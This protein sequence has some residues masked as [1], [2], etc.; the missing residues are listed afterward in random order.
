MRV[1]PERTSGLR[2]RPARPGPEIR[3]THEE[4]PL[5]RF[6]LTVIAAVLGVVAAGRAFAQGEAIP[7]TGTVTRQELQG[8]LE[9]LNEQLQTLQSDTDK[10][11]RFKFSG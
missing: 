1:R 9:G 2:S 8:L 4:G 7:D 6:S 5:K 3:G 10:L 11:K